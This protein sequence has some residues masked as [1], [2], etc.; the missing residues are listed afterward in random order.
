MT[1]SIAHLGPAGTYAEQ[2]AL[3]YAQ[4]W[5]DRTQKP[6]PWL[7]PFPSIAQTLYEVAEGRIDLAIAPVE[8]S[9]E[10]SVTMTL[11]T[12]WQVENLK[13]RQAIVL[14]IAHVLVAQTKDL[15][16]IARVYSHPQALGQCQ[17]WLHE[18]LPN[19][20]LIPTHSTTEALKYVEEDVAAISSERAAQLYDLPIRAR[21]IQDRPDNCTRFLVISRPDSSTVIPMVADGPIHTALA[22]S[23]LRNNPG[24]LVKPLQIFAERQ[25]NLSRIES[26]PTKRSLGDY[27]FFVDAEVCLKTKPFE[28]VIDLLK[29]NTESL[30]VLGYYSVLQISLDSNA[31]AT[32]L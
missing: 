18:N 11:D 29:Q 10:G 32:D 23:L 24:A 27:V 12:L 5:S 30:K 19:A 17:Q 28:S 4:W 3:A 7:I 8:N 22:F 1:L 20:K 16:A 15:S 13:I 2:A 6:L 21:S 9:I 25:I 26:R 31:I 14:P